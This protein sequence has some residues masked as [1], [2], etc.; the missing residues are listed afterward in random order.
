ML[1]GGLEF[2][3]LLWC[4]YQMFGPEYVSGVERGE[5]FWLEQIFINF[6]KSERRGFHHHSITSTIH[7]NNR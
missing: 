6:F 1:M 5:G 7:A 2:C 3:G 4:F